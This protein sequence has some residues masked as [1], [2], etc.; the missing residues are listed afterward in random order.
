MITIDASAQASVIA[1]PPQLATPEGQWSRDGLQTVGDVQVAYHR[2]ENAATCRTPFLESEDC[3]FSERARPRPL[4]AQE[5]MIDLIIRSALSDSVD[6]A[7]ARASPP[8]SSSTSSSWHHVNPLEG[9]THE[10]HTNHG[11][12]ASVNGAVENNGSEDDEDDENQER[13]AN[14]THGA[15]DRGPNEIRWPPASSAGKELPLL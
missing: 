3:T 5:H 14:Q 8:C 6:F 1:T 7:A 15:D 4:A 12:T 10:L 13:G 11:R 9:G 2:V